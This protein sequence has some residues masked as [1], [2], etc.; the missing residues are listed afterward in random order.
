VSG[1]YARTVCRWYSSL[2]DMI[3][4]DSSNTAPQIYFWPM[5]RIWMKQPEGCFF[6]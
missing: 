2:K 1:N 6:N 4:L 3:Y 5:G